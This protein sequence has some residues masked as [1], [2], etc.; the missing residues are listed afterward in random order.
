MS[1]K[2]KIKFYGVHK[3]HAL[4]ASYHPAIFSLR[5]RQIPPPKSLN[6]TIVKSELSGQ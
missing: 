3:K 2:K 1:F 5:G 4:K 6:V